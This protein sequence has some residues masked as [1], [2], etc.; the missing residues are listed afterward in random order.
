MDVGLVQVQ[1]GSGK[2][3]MPSPRIHSSIRRGQGVLTQPVQNLIVTG[4]WSEAARATSITQVS[5]NCRT[6]CSHSTGCA[7]KGG[8]SNALT[9]AELC[10]GDEIAEGSSAGGG[11]CRQ[12]NVKSSSSVGAHEL[13]GVGAT[14]TT[15]PWTGESATYL[16]DRI[17]MSDPR[18]GHKGHGDHHAHP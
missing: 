7:S 18:E 16:V 15:I 4:I 5:K 14:Q 1:T 8:R 3:H 9:V 17:R 10:A 13:Q 12:R 11:R 6:P 2:D